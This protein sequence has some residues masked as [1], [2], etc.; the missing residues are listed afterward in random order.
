MGIKGTID[1]LHVGRNEFEEQ[2]GSMG[3]ENER[4]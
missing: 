3:R 1:L 4:K 2:E